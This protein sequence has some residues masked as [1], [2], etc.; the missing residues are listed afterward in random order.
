MNKKLTLLAVLLSF[1]LLV[2]CDSSPTTVP[3]IQREKVAYVGT[4]PF[5]PPLVYQ[6]EAELVG[7]D[8]ELGQRIIDKIQETSDSMV[9]TDIKLM[10]INRT[11]SSLIPALQNHEVH[12]IMGV[13]A[14]TEDRQK[15][16]L[17]SD[18][19]YTSE[20][21]LVVNPVHKAMTVAQLGSANIG[22]REGTGVENFVKEKYSSSTVTPFKTLD[23]AILALRRSEVDCVIDDKFMAAYS[24]QETPGAAHMDFGPEVLG[25]IECGV[26]MRKGD[27]A[28]LDLAN[29]VIADVTGAGQFT[30]WLEE[31]AAGRVETVLARHQERLDQAKKASEPREITIRVSRAR[32]FTIDIYKMAN[33]R[34]VLTNQKTGEKSSS[35]PIRFE[36]STAVAKVTVPPGSYILA[37]HKFN[38]RSSI[39]IGPNDPKEVPIN[40]RLTSSGVVVRKG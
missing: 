11:Y 37:L 5:E 27:K 29:Q 6:E 39:D 2:A 30:E 23:D 25:T 35:S 8:A 22:V 13:F 3:D 38:F 10:W 12:F 4:V 19:Y 20:L 1:L 15:E 28:L 16:I 24:L 40:I 21:V 36:G 18:P 32:N 9:D 33:L 7:P 26:G 17:F 31:H 34:F 14:I